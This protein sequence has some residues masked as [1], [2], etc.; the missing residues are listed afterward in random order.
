M[1]EIEKR[2]RE[3]LAQEFERTENKVAASWLRDGAHVGGMDGDLVLRAMVAALSQGNP[4][5]SSGRQ[6]WS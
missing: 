3:L 5:T 4:P 1:N 2:A 6:K